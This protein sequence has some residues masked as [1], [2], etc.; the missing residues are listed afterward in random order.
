[1]SD[2]DRRLAAIRA[3]GGPETGPGGADLAAGP[4]LS[5]VRAYP[6]LDALDAAMEADPRVYRR[7]GSESVA[8]LEATLAAL[9]MPDG[10]TAPVARVT[11]SGQAALLLLVSATMMSGRRRVVVVRPCYGGTESLLVGPLAA[12]GVSTTM[13]DLPPPPAPTDV[14]ARLGRV[15]GADVALVVVEVVTNP[16]LRVVDVTAAAEAAHAVGAVCAVDS[17]L[18]TPF[19]FQPLVVGADLV[20]HSLT[21]H[22]GGHSDVLGGVALAAAGSEAADWL[23]AHSRAIGAVLSPFDAWLTLRGVR[24]APLRVERGTASAA[25]LAAALAD[26]PAA[27]AVHHPGTRGGEDA[28]LTARLLPRGGGPMLSIDVRGG[29]PAAS[30]VVRALHGVR[31]APSLGDVSTTVSHPSSTSH[32][33]LSPQARAALGIS[34]GLLRFSVGVEDE[35]VLIGELRA[36]LDAAAG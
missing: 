15:L 23:D 9:E 6:D 36:A 19:L 31:L 25:A 17:T 30:R 35:A 3:G 10:G 1:M 33:T 2:A 29:L 7:H 34:D 21:K 28:A 16:L 8:L 4:S 22:L 24:T 13:V 20:M 11:A 32:R 18:T 27:L 14:G 5:S 26:H 12:L